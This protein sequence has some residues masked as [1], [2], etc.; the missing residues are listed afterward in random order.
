[1]L[2]AEHLAANPAAPS[3]MVFPEDEQ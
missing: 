2:Y 3:D 1:M